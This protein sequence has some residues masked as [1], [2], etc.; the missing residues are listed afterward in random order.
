MGFEFLLWTLRAWMQ[1]SPC[2]CNFMC[3]KD[4][5]IKIDFHSKICP[6]FLMS[7]AWLSCSFHLVK[8]ISKLL[9][10]LRHAVALVVVVGSCFDVWGWNKKGGFLEKIWNKKRW[11]LEK[12]L[13]FSWVFSPRGGTSPL[14]MSS[15]LLLPG[16][17]TNTNCFGEHEWLWRWT[18][19]PFMGAASRAHR[20]LYPCRET[21]IFLGDRSN[22]AQ[23]GKWAR[24]ASIC[25][26]LSR[27]RQERREVPSS[28]SQRQVMAFLVFGVC[29]CVLWM[30]GLF[31]S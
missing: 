21:G 14:L 19:Q 3:I 24:S 27:A 22:K 15:G 31:F 16:G 5:V 17:A 1:R 2:T 23:G 13:Y 28:L 7:W 6:H 9:F 10:I 8:L 12:I 25:S 18:L 20:N 30:W 11:I 26:I 29:G 4:F